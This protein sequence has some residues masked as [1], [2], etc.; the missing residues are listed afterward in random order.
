MGFAHF[1]NFSA[2]YLDG[3]KILDFYFAAKL[4]NSKG[5]VNLGNSNFIHNYNMQRK[6]L[7]TGAGAQSA[8]RFLK[9]L[10]FDFKQNLKSIFYKKRAKNVRSTCNG[11]F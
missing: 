5:N 11:L 1:M 10:L 9:E 3:V 6:C 2:C 7:Q 8:L 4:L